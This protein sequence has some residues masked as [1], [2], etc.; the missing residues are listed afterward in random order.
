MTS[1]SQ[2]ILYQGLPG[3]YFICNHFWNLEK[4]CPRR[5]YQSNEVPK[6]TST[7]GGSDWSSIAAKH[8]FKHVNTSVNSIFLLDCNPYNNLN[9]NESM[10]ISSQNNSREVGKV[11]KVQIPSS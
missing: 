8:T 6:S 10:D 11:T 1:L 5:H 9:N 3:Q 2:R 7:V 4:D